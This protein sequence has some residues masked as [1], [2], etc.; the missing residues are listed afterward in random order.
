MGSSPE[1]NVDWEVNNYMDIMDGIYQAATQF[2]EEDSIGWEKRHGESY[3]VKSY[4]AVLA[5]EI[6]DMILQ[7]YEIEVNFPH[8]GIWDTTIPFKIAFSTWK[9]YWGRLQTIDKLISRGMNLV[10]ECALSKRESES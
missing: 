8:K 5:K 10:K 7:P 2:G 9:A 1:K 6:A 4:Y 3:T